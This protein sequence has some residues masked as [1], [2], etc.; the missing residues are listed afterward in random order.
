MNRTTKSL[1][2]AVAAFSFVAAACSSDKKAAETTVA[3]T[4]APSTAETTAPST[5][6]TTAASTGTGEAVSIDTNGDGKV[7]IGVATPGPRDDGGYYQ[8]L[9]DGVT[10]FSAANGFDKPIIVDNIKAEEASSALDGLAR[11]NVDMIAVGAGEIGD[12]LADLTVKYPDIIWYC[13]CGAGHAPLPNLIQSGD[14]GAEMGYSAGVATGILMRDRKTDPTAAMLGNN[15]FPFEIEAFKSFELGLQ[16]VDPTFTATYVA[17]N[18]FNDVAAATE[19]FNNLKDQGIGAIWPY[20]GGAADAV[21]KLSN[22][23]DVITMSAG[24]SD[25]CERTDLKFDIAVRFDA[26][27]YLDTILNEILAGKLKRG[28][29]RAFHVGVD[30]QGGAVIC[31]PTAEETTEMTAAYALI[32]SGDLLDQFGAIKG[33][34]YGG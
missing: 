9:V 34:A 10:D 4:T 31:D 12:P 15:N 17:T 19:A 22:E 30:P 28:E 18:S 29:T 27:D 5:A 16:S 23:N 8:A 1:I 20:L 33:E 24:A 14:D 32:A 3:A 25:A 7:V 21:V 13:N 26:G 2:A 6:E 11:Q